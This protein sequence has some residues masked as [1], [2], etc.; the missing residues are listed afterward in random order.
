MRACSKAG[1]G[2]ATVA[3]LTYDY[4]NSTVVLGPASTVHDP[5]A[6][7]LCE[8]HAEKLTVPR[9]WQVIRLQ[10]KFEPAPPSA[11]DLLALVDIVREATEQRTED[12]GARSSWSGWESR[13][14]PTSNNHP[15]EDQYAP[16]RNGRFSVIPG[17]APAPRPADPQ[18]R[19]HSQRGPL[20][21]S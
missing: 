8:Y 5:H 19:L 12:P 7:D 10:S 18:S 9:G 20:Q 6:L 13:G 3:T 17:E 2:R 21:E 15:E 11:D 16:L 14:D 4:G 1:C